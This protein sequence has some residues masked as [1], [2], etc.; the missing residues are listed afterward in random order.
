MR[1]KQEIFIR[2]RSREPYVIPLIIAISLWGVIFFNSKGFYYLYT[3]SCSL[4][5]GRTS[6]CT[7]LKNSVDSYL[8]FQIDLRYSV[9]Y[10]F[11]IYWSLSSSL[12]T[13]FDSISSNIDEVIS[14]NPSANIFVLHKDWLTCSA[15]TDRPGE[16][17]YNLFRWLTLLLR[18]LTVALK[19]LLSWI[20]L[21]LL[22]LVLFFSGFPTN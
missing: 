8:C 5:E 17:C 21:F 12:C 19:V 3:W 7:G 14:I 6:F 2:N 16:L 1:E 13:F 20:Y 9:S 11:F 18:S 22:M 10:L 15:G 4:C